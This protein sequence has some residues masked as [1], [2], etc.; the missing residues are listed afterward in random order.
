M[1]QVPSVLC[2]L[3]SLCRPNICF[4]VKLHFWLS[5]ACFFFSC[6]QCSSITVII[7]AVLSV[8]VILACTLFIFSAYYFFF[9]L[10]TLPGVLNLFSNL[11]IWTSYPDFVFLFH[12]I[13]WQIVIQRTPNAWDE[14]KNSKVNGVN[15]TLTRSILYLKNIKKNCVYKCSHT[16][17]I[18]HLMGNSSTENYLKQLL[19]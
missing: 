1:S 8:T 9:V 5:L 2:N 19:N 10:L 15:N 6:F 7:H 17:H 18:K 14:I 16:F 12:S 11:H 3:Y 4:S 13:L